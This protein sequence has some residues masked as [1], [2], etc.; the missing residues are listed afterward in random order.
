MQSETLIRNKNVNIV[1]NLEAKEVAREL[2]KLIE[3]RLN[4]T[5]ATEVSTR[6]EGNIIEKL[7]DAVTPFVSP[8]RRNLPF[9]SAY[10][11]AT[12]LDQITRNTLVKHLPAM[13]VLDKEIMT[14]DIVAN[15]M[16]TL[17]AH[18]SKKLK[19]QASIDETKYAIPE[20]RETIDSSFASDEE[21]EDGSDDNYGNEDD[22]NDGY[23]DS[24]IKIL[25]QDIIGM[26]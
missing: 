17:K 22:D 6:T 8:S 9:A 20:K 16:T 25:R 19:I 1:M 13:N 10:Q 11:V 5:T 12:N 3:M 7:E 2:W 18:S 23:T 21:Y 4:N 24:R 26:F 15:M 14:R